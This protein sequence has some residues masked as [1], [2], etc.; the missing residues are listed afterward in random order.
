MRRRA[1][2]LVELLVVI[3]VIGILVALLLPAVQAAR[4]AA[5]RGQCSSN[6]R[7]IGLAMHG[8]HDRHDCFPPGNINLGTCCNTPSYTSW[9]LSLLPYIE[10]QNLADQ[11][12][13]D[14]TNE[15]AANEPVCQQYVSVYLCPSDVNPRGLERPESGPGASHLYQPGSY[16]GVGGRS[17]GS[18]WWDNYPQ[19]TSLPMTWRG[20]LHT[21]DGRDLSCE[22]FVTI[23]DGSSNTLL[24]GE[25]ATRTHLRRRTFW[26]YSYGSFNKSDATPF[27][28]AL[29]N[30][31]DRCASVSGPGLLDACKRGFGS[32]HGV[33]QFILA[34]GSVRGIS[35]N[36]DTTLFCELATIAGGEAASG[37]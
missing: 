30:D 6:L 8:Y 19:Y 17:D 11:Y 10:Q 36:L 31:Y 15:N 7:Q 26:A 22:S 9:P 25:Y 20:V 2:T 13:W 1:F 37:L 33:I 14:L 4:E 5:R 3:A 32:S 23:Q 16:R 29:L 35:P 24:V 12:R 18:G 34:D 27:G 21:V 28:F